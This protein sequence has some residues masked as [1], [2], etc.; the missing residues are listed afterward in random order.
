MRTLKQTVNIFGEAISNY[1]KNNSSR[2]DLINKAKAKF[3]IDLDYYFRKYED[4][5]NLEK[6]GLS[7]TSGEILD[8]GCAT[9]YYI[10]ILRRYGTVD[11]I[12][13]SKHA[14]KIARANGI[15]ECHVADIF[16]YNPGKKYDT[17]TLFENNIGLA[18]TYSKTKRMFRKLT[19]LLKINGQIIAIVRHTDYRDKYYSS[20]YK[21]IW[22]EKIRKGFRWFYFNINFL[23]IFCRKYNL[24]LEI[25][26]EDD[27]EGRKMYL[28]RL[29]HH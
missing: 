18:G 16:K 1:S 5:S 3:S 9:G 6:K 20:K 26:D 13:I 24:E 4:L 7:L 14:I 27:D 10:P 25:L 29:L 28:I 22:K 12:D 11:A 8:V 2:L 23:P 15:K 21:I 19:N 17:V